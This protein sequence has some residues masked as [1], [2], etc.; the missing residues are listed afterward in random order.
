MKLLAIETATP[1]M[2]LAVTDGETLVASYE[3]LAEHPHAAELPGGV[4]RVLQ[5]AHLSLRELDAI[6]VDIGPGSFTGLRIGLAFA[7]A[8]AF[9][10]KKPVVGV[11]S[12]DVLAAGVPYAAMPM[13]PILD[14]KQKNLYAAL[15]QPADG[16]PARQ[17]DY[18]LGPIEEVL[19]FAAAPSI[20]LGDGCARYRER[21][22]ERCP[23]AR[24]APPELWLPRAATL[25]RLG[26]ARRL[27]GEADDPARLVPMYLYPQD[28]QV[29]SPDRPTSVIPKLVRPAS[30]VSSG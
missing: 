16:A 13:F 22:L 4:T 12:L 8:L 20:L 25:A 24:I 19:A 14:A 2:G 10:T 6:V 17:S 30:P 27:R 5:A 26:R 1:S 23:G 29:R 11:A 9:T 3:L 15:Y 7:K 21:I 28:C 18:L